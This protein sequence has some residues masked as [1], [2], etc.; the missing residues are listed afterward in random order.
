MSNWLASVWISIQEVYVVLPLL[1]I[2]V[3]ES[4]LWCAGDW[5]GM[6]SSD[7][8][9]GRS[10]RPSAE[11]QEWSS[12]GQVLGGRMIQRS[13]DAV[14]YLHRAQGDEEHGFLGLATKPRSTVCQWFDLKTTGL[15]F[16]VW[17]SKLTTTVWWFR[18]Q[19]HRSGFLVW[20]S[21]PC[22]LRFV[23][24]ATE[25]KGEWRW[26]GARAEIYKLTSHGSK[27]G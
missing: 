12:I 15:G 2:L 7:E 27:L 24:C 16:L 23:G 1:S 26:R 11:D 21:Q 9:S 22:R 17:A 8:D 14:C 18:P 19:N 25:P 4:R 20:A 13:G 10:R 3:G 6:A 5:C